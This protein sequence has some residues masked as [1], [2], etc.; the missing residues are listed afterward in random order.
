M[1]VVNDIDLK[2]KAFVCS[3]ILKETVEVERGQVGFSL[4]EP[5]FTEASSLELR[6]VELKSRTCQHC[7]DQSLPCC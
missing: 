4:Q 1:L 2:M 7:S 6:V 3:D 5:V